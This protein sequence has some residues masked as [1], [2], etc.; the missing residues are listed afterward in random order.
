MAAA[1]DRVRM[2]L[3]PSTK[4]HFPPISGS[5]ILVPA[6]PLQLGRK[7]NIE[8][9]KERRELRHILRPPCPFDKDR[10]HITTHSCHRLDIVTHSST[11]TRITTEHAHQRAGSNQQS[12]PAEIVDTRLRMT[13]Y[14]ATPQLL[15]PVDGTTTTT[16]QCSARR[17]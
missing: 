16:P 12:R 7:K 1:A 6:P 9:E 2:M 13:C 8:K 14:A 10:S 17:P 4:W 3:G 5:Y 11:S 15:F